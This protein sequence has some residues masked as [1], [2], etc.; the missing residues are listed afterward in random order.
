[1]N[2]DS[3]LVGDVHALNTAT[4]TVV[5]DRLQ[6]LMGGRCTGDSGAVSLEQVLWFVAS[7][8]S[9]AVVAGVLWGRIR[10][11]AN[12]PIQAPSAP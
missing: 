2:I 12:L 11:Q 7:G 9:V 4:R 1:M 3:Q 5:L 10:T 6:R 8:V